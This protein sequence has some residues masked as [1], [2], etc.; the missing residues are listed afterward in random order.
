MEDLNT[1]LAV[2]F[3][4]LCIKLALA[5]A[6]LDEL[7]TLLGL[8]NDGRVFLGELIDEIRI[9]W[10]V[11]S[12]AAVQCWFSLGRGVHNCGLL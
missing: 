5:R 4:R 2:P 9:W 3:Q 8:L 12:T 6:A 1:N 11:E 7:G 10:L